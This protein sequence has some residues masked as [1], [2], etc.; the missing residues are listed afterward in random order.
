[1]KTKLKILICLLGIFLSA[2]T[3]L[4]Q[5]ENLP[6]DDSAQVNDDLG[7]VTDA[8]QENFFEAI[9]ALHSF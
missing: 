8:F 9:L 2:P 7:T 3:T 1:M 5:D 4:A 6:N